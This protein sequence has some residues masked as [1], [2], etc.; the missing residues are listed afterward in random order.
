MKKQTEKYEVKRFLVEFFKPNKWKITL[1]IV[2]MLTF[3]FFLLIGIEQ[4]VIIFYLPLIVSGPFNISTSGGFDIV[5][6]PTIFSTFVALLIYALQTYL[7]S[8]L[9]ML[10]Y[11]KIKEL[12]TR[13]VKNK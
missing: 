2:L 5:V 1:S 9:L 12:Y 13:N 4:V 11:N 7:L 8:C 3:F 6:I 10:I